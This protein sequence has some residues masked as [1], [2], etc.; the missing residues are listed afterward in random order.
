MDFYN[1]PE[2]YGANIE[3][4]VE[5]VNSSRLLTTSKEMYLNA[6]NVGSQCA[7]ADVLIIVDSVQDTH[8]IDFLLFDN[9]EAKDNFEEACGTLLSEDMENDLRSRIMSMIRLTYPVSVDT[10]AK[11]S[12]EITEGWLEDFKLECFIPQLRVY[13]V[14]IEG[15]LS[16]ARIIKN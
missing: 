2:Y 14:H 11:G 8:N 12:R 10:L 9:P 3:E 1:I 6:I 13:V 5:F 15:T 16:D 4:M 7:E